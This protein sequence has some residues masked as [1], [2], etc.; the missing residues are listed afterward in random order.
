MFRCGTPRLCVQVVVATF[1]LISAI[2]IVPHLIAQTPDVLSLVDRG[3][4]LVDAQQFDQALQVFR[5]ADELSHHTCADCYLGMVRAESQLGDFQGALA[6]AQRAVTAAGDDHIVAAQALV[7]RAGLLL[8][9]SGGP[10]DPKLREAQ[11]DYR[12][13]LA[14]DPKKSIARFSLG[15]LLLEENRDAE[16]VAELK[17]YVSGPFADPRHVDRAN[18]LIADPNRARALPSEDFSLATVDGRT[19][20]KQSLRG[21]VVLLDFWASWCPPCRE[22]VPII[23]DL[24]H[25]FA[26]VA[27]EVVGINADADEST[28]QSFT[29]SHGMDWPEFQDLDGQISELFEIQ[30]LPTYVVLARD[31][32]IAFQ[33]TG[34][35]SDTQDEL[36]NVIA[37][38]LAKPAPAASAPA[39]PV[40]S[41]P[42]APVVAAQPAANRLPIELA[43]PPDDVE[44][45]DADSGLYRNEFLALSYRFPADWTAASADVLDQLN[46]QRSQ[47][48]QARG[49]SASDGGLAKNGS[50]VVPFPQIVFQASADPRGQAPA[51]SLAVTQSAL[52]PIDF[53]HRETLGLKQEGATI[54]AEPAPVVVGNRQFVRVDFQDSQDATIS[55]ARFETVARPGFIVTLEVRARSKQ[56]LEQ[57]AAE[58]QNLAITTR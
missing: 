58:A 57:L 19:I 16:G 8:A 9:T 51:V 36:N 56:E 24:H 6:D 7:T 46:Q 3:N 20:S 14:L 2:I 30:G 25:K 21:K 23:V 38:E 22:S 40:P 1:L 34:L 32:T 10:N 4:S 15:V 26:S 12:Q 13:A 29:G 48:M 44:N 33:Q 52:S 53:A 39:E 35:G 42:P 55:V 54:L 47:Q 41:P 49:A 18:R 45:G 31:G 27:F 17:A 28:L 50:V 37:K 11:D 5:D 43:Y